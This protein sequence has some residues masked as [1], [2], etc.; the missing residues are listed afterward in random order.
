MTLSDDAG[1][2]AFSCYDAKQ[3]K[4]KLWSG[5]SLRL[6]VEAPIDSLLRLLD[7]GRHLAFS[8]LQGRQLRQRWPIPGTSWHPLHNFDQS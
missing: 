1:D 3:I 2:F 8:G 7:R 6:S 5:G 4:R